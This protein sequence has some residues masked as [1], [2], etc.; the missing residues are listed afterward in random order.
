MQLILVHFVCFCQ[1][2]LVTVSPDQG[3]TLGMACQAA[4]F[5]SSVGAFAVALSRREKISTMRTPVSRCIEQRHKLMLQRGVPYTGF[6]IFKGVQTRHSIAMLRMESNASQ[7]TG[8]LALF[9]LHTITKIFVTAS[10]EH[11]MVEF[12]LNEMMVVFV[13]SVIIHHTIFLLLYKFFQMLG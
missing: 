5:A 12:F 9:A 4:L 13:P 7:M 8:Q 1:K 11:T 3:L 10:A 6:Q 2:F